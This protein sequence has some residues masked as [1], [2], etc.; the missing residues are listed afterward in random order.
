MITK[1]NMSISPL[2]KFR[3]VAKYD[4][5]LKKSYQIG[6]VLRKNGRIEVYS[7]FMLVNEYVNPLL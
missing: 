4:Q 2:V 1:T 7:D 3:S 5:I 6:I